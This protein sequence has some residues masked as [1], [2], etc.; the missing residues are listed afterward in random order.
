VAGLGLALAQSPQPAAAPT[1]ELLR[2][3]GKFHALLIG[4]DDYSSLPKLSS[5]VN[6]ARSLE[7]EL[8]DKYGFE[9]RLLTDRQ[10]TRQDILKALSYYRRA[11]HE[12]D[13]LLIYFAGHGLV[14]R[15]SNRSYWLPSD[16]SADPS[17]EW[18][19]SD[20]ITASLRATPA[21]HVLVISDSVSEAGLLSRAAAD[22]RPSDYAAYLAR[23]QR[24]RSRTVMGSG[25]DEP[26]LDGAGNGHS[27]FTG[28]ILRGLRILEG[29]AFSAESLYSW[30][31]R[32]RVAGISKQVPYYSALMNSGHDGG[33]FVFLGTGREQSNSPAAPKTLD[34]AAQEEIAFWDKVDATD[35]DSLKLYLGRYPGGRFADLANLSL[36]RISKPVPRDLPARGVSLPEAH[37]RQVDAGL[38]VALVI[39]VDHYPENSGLRLIAAEERKRGADLSEKL[40]VIE[41][42]DPEF[43][44]GLNVLEAQA[45]QQSYVQLAEFAQILKA[46]WHLDS[47]GART[48]EL[49]RN[50]L[51]VAA[52]NSLTLLE[53]SPLLTHAAFRAACLNRVQS[54]EVSNYFRTMVVAVDPNSMTVVKGWPHIGV[55]ALLGLAATPNGVY[56]LSETINSACAASVNCPTEL[57]RL[58][59]DGTYTA[60][61]QWTRSAYASAPIFTAPN[62]YMYTD[63]KVFDQSGVLLPQSIPVSSAGVIWPTNDPW[64]VYENGASW[65]YTA[66]FSGGSGVRWTLYTTFI[67]WSIAAQRQPVDGTDLVI[68]YRDGALEYYAVTPPILL[69]GAG[70]ANAASFQFGPVAPGSLVTFFGQG[71]GTWGQSTPV[72]TTKVVTQVGN[73]K[74]LLGQ[75]PLQLTYVGYGQINAQLPTDLAD[76]TYQTVVYGPTS[77]AVGSTT[78]VDQAV[79]AFLWSP[80]PANPSATAPILTNGNYQLIGDPALSPAYA[81]LSP[82][83]FGVV[84]MTG[85]GAT[86]PALNGATFVVPMPAPLYWLDIL[87]PV[88]VDNNQ[89]AAVLYAGLVPGCVPGLNQENFVVPAGLTPGAHDITLGTITYKGGLW[90]K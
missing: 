90:I 56:T 9:T 44:V 14:D 71:F 46:R 66:D 45:G 23:L 42:G 33:D 54:G 40:I 4:I 10:A 86:S 69:H 29:T 65:L 13:D 87:P 12:D 37:D 20:D 15:Q 57:G 11:L 83:D 35:P 74:V 3:A 84:W 79:A 89:A 61:S 38:R 50:I 30:Y 72:D 47:L 39:G 64:F 22:A 60:L 80:D 48:E 68:T 85:G 17:V 28:A 36:N 5:A 8:R 59:S 82:G 77:Y 2:N 19:A 7:A 16:S 25:A 49:L 21:R 1:A 88:L 6:D 81:Q 78:I 43:S 27:V 51:H 31:V 24:D 73:T 58:N 76:G 34:L 67:Y 52:D 26:V 70:A 55:G 53:I 62:G 41:P 63:S 75:K 32:E 18:I